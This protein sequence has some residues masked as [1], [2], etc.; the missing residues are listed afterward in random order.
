M[1]MSKL[2]EKNNHSQNQDETSLENILENMKLQFERR[3]YE[4]RE[5][6]FSAC[7]KAVG[8]TNSQLFFHIFSKNKNYRFHNDGEFT[9]LC[10]DMEVFLGRELYAELMSNLISLRDKKAQEIKNKAPELLTHT[11]NIPPE[12]MGNTLVPSSNLNQFGEKRGNFIFA[13]ES[14]SERDF[15]A[16]RVNDKE[17]KNI[18]WK[19][20]AYINGEEKNVFIMEKINENSYTYFVPKE[21]FVPVVC[22]DGRFGHEWTAI[23]EIQYLYCEK[24]NIEDIKKRNIIKIVDRDKFYSK[25]KDEAFQKNL[26]NP[27]II[28]STLDNSGVLNNNYKIIAELA[29]CF[30]VQI[31]SKTNNNSSKTDFFKLKMYQNKKQNG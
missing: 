25:N 22:L 7:S 6:F 20:K 21:N 11:S 14:D 24:N 28:I 3:T 9:R 12:I 15:Y 18:N 2:L 23:Q 31:A 10:K 8:F 17:G 26:N 29:D 13:T 16:L 1:D 5:N 27:H 19:K 30:N 4:D